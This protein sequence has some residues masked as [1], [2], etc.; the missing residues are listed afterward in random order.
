MRG[1]LD[2]GYQTSCTKVKEK[3][4]KIHEKRKKLTS[5]SSTYHFLPSPVNSGPLDGLCAGPC[6]LHI[7]RDN[8]ACLPVCALGWMGETEA[9]N[10]QRWQ[11]WNQG[12]QR[13][14]HLTSW[15]CKWGLG[16]AELYLLFQVHNAVLILI[17][18]AAQFRHCFS[19]LSYLFPNWGS[20][21]SGSFNVI[22]SSSLKLYFKFV[23]EAVGFHPPKRKKEIRW[24]AKS[25]SI[26]IVH[27]SR[28]LSFHLLVLFPQQASMEAMNILSQYC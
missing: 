7:F 28:W 14:P 2:A 9:L 19:K 10:F 3:V 13:S 17:H 12:Y 5:S 25:C 18:H 21:L 22:V 26:K 24:M 8:W 23:R 27:N 11:A 6:G 16:F 4:R 20:V 1:H 15:C